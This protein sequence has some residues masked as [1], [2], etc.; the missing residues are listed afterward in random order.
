MDD[1]TWD[2]GGVAAGG[3]PG[4]PLLVP[5]QRLSSLSSLV[6]DP[7]GD[8]A[9]PRPETRRPR[10]GNELAGSRLLGRDRDRGGESA[11][12]P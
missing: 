3:R 10:V 7:N 12:F 2:A 9:D 5:V 6:F 1:G 8:L 11:R 4:M